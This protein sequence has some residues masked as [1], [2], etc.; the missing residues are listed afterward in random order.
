MSRM[1]AGFTLVELL[2]TIAL[3]AILLAIGVPSYQSVT[4]ANRMSGEINGLVG[5]LQYARA[6]AV[7]QGQNV[8]VCAS[9][10][11]TSCSGSG[12]WSNGWIV[13]DSNNNVLKVQQAFGGTDTLASSGNTL[14]SIA[15]NRYGFTANSGTLTLHDQANTQTWRKCVVVS[16]VGELTLN[17]QGACP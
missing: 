13:V 6:E 15:Y 17:S 16:P 1:A 10:N 9:S 11:G 7:K 12:T 2:V 8:T 4:T 3:I 5:N 14:S